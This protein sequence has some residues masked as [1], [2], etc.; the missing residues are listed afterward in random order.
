[1]AVIVSNEGLLKSENV[2]E[3][4]IPLIILGIL[5]ILLGITI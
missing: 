3:V 4:R 1:M 5:M 2:K